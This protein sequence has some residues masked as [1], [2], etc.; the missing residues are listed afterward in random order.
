VVWVLVLLY[1]KTTTFFEH[2]VLICSTSHLLWTV[3]IVKHDVVYVDMLWI[4]CPMYVN[5]N[6]IA[7]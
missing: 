1:N 5:S 7:C 6:L 3:R 4:Q 2:A